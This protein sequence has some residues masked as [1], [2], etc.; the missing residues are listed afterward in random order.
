[1]LLQY[2]IWLIFLL[3]SFSFS[4]VVLYGSIFCSPFKSM[5]SFQKVAHFKCYLVFL[6]LFKR[7]HLQFGSFFSTR[8]FPMSNPLNG[9][10]TLTFSHFFFSCC[11][12]FK[13]TTKFHFR[14]FFPELV[15]GRRIEKHN[16]QPF[17][18][19]VYT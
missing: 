16:H 2:G 17:G 10:H 9:H 14:P 19:F 6:L 7:E 13:I 8:F 18:N 1:M 12:C 15:L 4:L 5:N 3:L 11:C